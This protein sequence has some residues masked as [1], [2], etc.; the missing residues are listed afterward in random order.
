MDSST[1][2]LERRCDA[3]QSTYSACQAFLDQL[4]DDATLEVVEVKADAC[5][6]QNRPSRGRR[7]ARHAYAG[8]GRRAPRQERR[9]NGTAQTSKASG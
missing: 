1:P 6:Y 4:P 9:V 5:P 8:R 2:V 7:A 3:A